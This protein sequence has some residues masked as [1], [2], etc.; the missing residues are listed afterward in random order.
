[1]KAIFKQSVTSID[2]I[3]PGAVA[4]R[5]TTNSNIIESGISQQY[6]LAI[7]ATSFTVG[8]FIVAFVKDALLTLVATV[9]IPIVLVAY[10]VA[11]P[12]L[13]KYWYQAEAEKDL[14]TSLAYEIFQSIRIVVA[15]GAEQRLSSEHG[16]MMERARKID[17]KQAPI[18]GAIFAPMFLAIY[19]IF[20][21]TFWYG[22]RQYTKGK[23]HNVGTIIGKPSHSCL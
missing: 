22:V 20:A 2:E 7:Q 19:G 8:L 18:M 16:K 10:A 11:V 21:L 3:S 5:L 17:R 1:M 9:A 15:F 12:F 13:N 23:I 4:T 6:F 14:A